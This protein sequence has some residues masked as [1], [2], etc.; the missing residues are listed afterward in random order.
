MKPENRTVADRLLMRRIALMIYLT[1][2]QKDTARVFDV[3]ESY[4]DRAW[5]EL[6]HTLDDALR[7]PAKRATLSLARLG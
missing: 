7:A 6:R 3:S 1:G 5:R 2:D 4:V